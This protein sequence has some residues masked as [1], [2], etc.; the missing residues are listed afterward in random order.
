M[1]LL[2]LA[3]APSPSTACEG[4]PPAAV[5]PDGVLGAADTCGAWSIAVDGHL[6]VQLA[7][8]DPEVDCDVVLDEPLALFSSPIFA[9]MNGDPPSWTFDVTAAEPADAA[10]LEIAC[11]DDTRFGGWVTA[12]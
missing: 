12:S 3:C 2:L 7:V 8:S 11:T 4:A 6:Y 1:L 9:H 10:Y 5:A